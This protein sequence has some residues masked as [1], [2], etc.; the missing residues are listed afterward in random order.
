MYSVIKRDGKVAE[1]DISK[2]TAAITK[3]FEAQ[4]KQYHSSVID[5]LGLRVTAEFESKVHGVIQRRDDIDEYRTSDRED[6]QTFEAYTAVQVEKIPAVVPP[7]FAVGP[8]QIPACRIFDYA[9]DDHETENQQ[10]ILL[11]G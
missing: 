10:D 2:I 8:L 7:S 11:Q 6:K 3:A 5:L 4:N 1:F 9:A